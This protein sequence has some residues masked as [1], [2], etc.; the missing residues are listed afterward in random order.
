MFSARS[1]GTDEKVAQ[2]VLVWRS[3]DNGAIWEK[4]IDVPNLRQASPV[5][6][7][8]AA[9]GTPYILCNQS[10]SAF[11]ATNGTL[12]EGQGHCSFREMVCLWPLDAARRTLLSPVIVR[13]PRYE[14]GVPPFGGDWMCDHANGNTIRLA[15]GRAHHLICY[16]LQA[17]AEVGGFQTD[18]PPTPHSGQWV[19]EL[20]TDGPPA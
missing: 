1:S 15:D 3:G 11:I 8:Q 4:V 14:F 2:S 5:T 13:Y 10:L 17:H 12:L 20:F 7:N 19:E 6:L 18:A 16:R 9:D